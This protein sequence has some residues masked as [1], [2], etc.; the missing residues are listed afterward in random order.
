MSTG[1]SDDSFR[2]FF[3]GSS[4]TSTI[5]SRSRASLSR[6]RS[7]FL[8]RKRPIEDRSHPSHEY[9][10]VERPGP[11]LARTAHPLQ[12]I[13][14]DRFD[15]LSDRLRGR[16]GEPSGLSWDDRL[17]VPAFVD[18]HDG[19]AG[20]HRLDRREPEVLVLRHGHEPATPR[21]QVQ[22]LGFRNFSEEFDV[23]RWFQ[24]SDQAIRVHAQLRSPDNDEALSRE[25]AK[26]IDEEPQALLVGA[27]A[28]GGPRLA[29]SPDAIAR[30]TEGRGD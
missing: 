10:A 9:I 25:T 26:R 28:D 5:R 8:I 29:N 17:S 30:R 15:R 27:P 24:R 3:R 4:G 11:I 7:E 2:E 14:P 20:G 13:D 19:L 16:G 6:R 18:R 23:C 22:Q 12:V 1:T 21:V